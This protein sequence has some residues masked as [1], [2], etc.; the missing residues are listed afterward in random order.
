MKN[1]MKNPLV[2][3]IIPVYNGERFLAAS[4]QSVLA[5]DYRP[6]EII[7]VDDGSTDRSGEI[8]RAYAEVRCIRQ[9]NGGVSAARNAGIAAA[10]GEFVAWLDADDLW[11]ADKLR[12]QMDYHLAQPDVGYTVTRQRIFLEPGSTVPSFLTDELLQNDHVGFFPSTLV[13]RKTVYD[14][15]GGYDT[16]FHVTESADWFARAKDAGIRMEIVPHVLLHKR[17]HETNMTRD[18]VDQNRRNVLRILK[19]SIDRRRAQKNET[20][21]EDD[22][23]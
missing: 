17:A 22:G 11:T 4:I 5:Q 16:D 19:A 21:D 18:T 23:E 2:S 14:R 10:R 7:V 6:I 12:V 1:P 20:G 15:V 8:A 9:P 13:V 3:A